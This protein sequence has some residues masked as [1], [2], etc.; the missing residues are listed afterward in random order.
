MRLSDF[1]SQDRLV[2][3]LIDAILTLY[4]CLVLAR[5]FISSNGNRSYWSLS[6]CL[7]M[8]S[9]IALIVFLSV[10]LQIIRSE[11]L[12]SKINLSTA[13]ATL[14]SSLISLIF[15]ISLGRSW[16]KS[17]D[18]GNKRGKSQ[19][20]HDALQIQSKML[21]MKPK[22]VNVDIADRSILDV[23]D[24]AK[25]LLQT[26]LGI[27][28]ASNSGANIKSV[29]N[30]SSN[31]TNSFM[32]DWKLSKTGYSS[33]IWLST[34][35]SIKNN[36]EFM[37]KG[38]GYSTL[39]T[40]QIVKYLHSNNKYFGCE[41]LM[42]LVETL[43]IL[44]HGRIIINRLANTTSSTKIEY[45]VITTFVN[46]DNGGILI[47][48]KS[49]PS[50][51]TSNH[52]RKGFHLNTILV[53]GYV[54]LPVLKDQP[55]IQISNQYNE[56]GSESNSSSYLIAKSRIL[57][58]THMASST[59]TATSSSS[60]FNS[61]N[62]T[63]ITSER[64]VNGTLQLLDYLHVYKQRMK[65][66]PSPSA[67]LQQQ[68]QQ[69]MSHDEYEAYSD[70][71]ILQS[72]LKS[73]AINNKGRASNHGIETQNLSSIASTAANALVQ[74]ID[75]TAILDEILFNHP[76][77]EYISVNVHQ[78]IEMLEI[79]QNV[80][81]H[82]ICL[83]N[84]VNDIEDSRK[85]DNKPLLSNNSEDKRQGDSMCLDTLFPLTDSNIASSRNANKT[86]YKPRNNK[87]FF[88]G[89][90]LYEIDQLASYGNYNKSDINNNSS[91]QNLRNTHV[92]AT[93]NWNKFYE[94]EGITLSEYVMNGINCVN[95]ENATETGGVLSAHC[96]IQVSG[97]I[98]Y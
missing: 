23:A 70:E 89:K 58:L 7:D 88:K 31:S 67:Q 91:Y 64:I 9:H 10:T 5:V 20:N 18:K 55:Q 72:S 43:Q 16:R 4:V 26:T 3:T 44:Q 36:N 14:C 29:L 51:Y 87:H 2:Q 6:F 56:N 37:I 17:D 66:S 53:S 24:E 60:L 74:Q 68:Q 57:F 82:I 65:P 12:D 41:G 78:K 38:S 33:H 90:E 79:S 97:H 19:K 8:S 85:N 34:N 75:T 86:S 45:I 52:K 39:N 40:I 25:Y 49:L 54:I 15:G 46:L 21:A 80:I 96:H 94:M 28:N 35:K 42:T 50:S 71:A 98:W 59:A 22:S 30:N 62:D 1:I 69:Q 83:Y 76:V 84:S 11:H 27:E 32:R 93:E 61:F 47:A 63:N 81:L 92:Y 77:E 13:L 95:R 48:T 73:A